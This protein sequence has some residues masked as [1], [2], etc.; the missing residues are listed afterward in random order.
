MVLAVQY[1]QLK[2]TQHLPKTF[3]MGTVDISCSVCILPS[4]YL[5]MYACIYALLSSLLR[6]HDVCVM[7]VIRSVSRRKT[8]SSPAEQLLALTYFTAA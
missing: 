7:Y 5:C 2:C 3:A 6:Q 1:V 4:I 8:C